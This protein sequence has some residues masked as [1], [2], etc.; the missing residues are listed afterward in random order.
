MSDK[1]EAKRMKSSALPW[2]VTSRV[3]A[4]ERRG[5]SDAEQACL[6]LESEGMPCPM[7]VDAETWVRANF[8]YICSKYME[9]YPKPSVAVLAKN[10]SFKA[11]KKALAQP[12]KKLKIKGRPAPIKHFGIDVT[13][14]EFLDTY[15]WRKLRMEALIQYGRKCMCCGA[16]PET[17]A[18]M[19]VDHIK[20]RKRYPE[21]ALKI[22]NLQILCHDCNHGKG[23]WN[24][25]DWRNK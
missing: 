20:P 25:T 18:V 13:S 14:T 22:N 12:S 11:Q 17:G 21:L 1:T 6:A 10:K 4:A 5:L 16:T 23:N 9:K 3:S 8:L 24:E 15:Q 2:F 7:N 19:N